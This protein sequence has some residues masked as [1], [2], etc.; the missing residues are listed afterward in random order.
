MP[1]A[2]LYHYGGAFTPPPVETTASWLNSRFPT[3]MTERKATVNGPTQAKTGLEWA[4]E[5]PGTD[6]G[7]FT[8]ASLK[9]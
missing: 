1:N 4:A 3:G 6:G 8:K 5:K 9:G 7:Q 2:D